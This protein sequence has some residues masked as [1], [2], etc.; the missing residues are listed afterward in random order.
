M[1]NSVLHVQIFKS[2]ILCMKARVR[3]NSRRLV[4]SDH[5]ALYFILGPG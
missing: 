1:N 4:T 3:F 5:I 2:G